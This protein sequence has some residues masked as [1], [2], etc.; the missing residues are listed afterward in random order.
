MALVRVA[1]RLVMRVLIAGLTLATG[2]FVHADAG[3]FESGDAR[4][5]MD[6]QLLNDA[7]IIRLPVNTWPMPR[8]AVEYALSNAK[9]HFAVNAAVKRGGRPAVDRE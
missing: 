3:W 1:T 5:R 7:E 2:G 8:A 6:L 4:L 9:T